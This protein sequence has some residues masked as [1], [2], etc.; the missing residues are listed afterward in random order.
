MPGPVPI[1]GTSNQLKKSIGRLVIKINSEIL[2]FVHEKRKIKPDVPLSAKGN[3]LKETIKEKKEALEEALK[4]L[5]GKPDYIIQE[6]MEK[7]VKIVKEN[8]ATA[9][10][11]LDVESSE[12]E[13]EEH[14]VTIANNEEVENM[15]N[16][17]QRDC[18]ATLHD[19][20]DDSV[21]DD[22]EGA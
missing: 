22:S 19:V 8:I 4:D 10:K 11:A 2:D 12:V 7:T 15:E 20:V 14:D 6:R 16:L 3:K 21:I 5:E 1:T 9:N 13:I 17:A 18:L